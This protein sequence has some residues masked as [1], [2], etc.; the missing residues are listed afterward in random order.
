MLLQLQT[1]RYIEFVLTFG[2]EQDIIINSCHPR[3]RHFQR[4]ISQ[5]SISFTKSATCESGIVLVSL[6]M[7]YPDKSNQVLAKEYS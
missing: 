5:S 7:S 1:M 2:T 3:S 6:R 4:S